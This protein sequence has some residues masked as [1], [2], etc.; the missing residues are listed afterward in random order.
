MEDCLFCKIIAGEIPGKKVYE[1][2][3]TYVFMDVAKDV[4]GHMLVVPKKHFKNILD[5]DEESL[6]HVILTAQ[7]VS[8]HLVEDCGYDGIVTL[9]NNNECVGQSVFHYHMHILPKKNADGLAGWPP[10]FEGAKYDLDEVF[11]KVKM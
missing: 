4:D 5:A 9:N 11:N 8:K 6:K 10:K 3:F 1:D 2:E 7:K